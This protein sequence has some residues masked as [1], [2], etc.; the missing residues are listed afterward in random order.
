VLPLFF[1]ISLSHAEAIKRVQM[2]DL[3]REVRY[4]VAVYYD[5]NGLAADAKSARLDVRRIAVRHSTGIFHPKNIFA[6]L[7]TIEPDKNGYHAQTLIVASMSA[8]L[9]RAGWWENVEV[10]HIEQVEDGELTRLKDDIFGLLEGLERRVFE[11]AA[12]GHAALKAIKAFLRSTAQRQLRSSGGLL[13]TH[14]FDGGTAV[15]E[16]LEGVAGRDLRGLNLEIISPY[17]DAGPTS[18][19]L[20][21]LIER[22]APSEVRVFL[23]K[24]EAGE[25][26]CSKEIFDWVKLQPS[27][28]WS[29]LPKEVTRGG[30][31]ENAKGRTVHAKVYRFFSAQP[32]REFLFVGSANLTDPAHRR[33]GNLETGFLVQIDSPRRPDWWMELDGSKPAK[34]V[35]RNEEEGAVSNSGSRLTLRYWW[36]LKLA[37]AYWDDPG[38]SRVLSVSWTGIALFDIDPLERRQWTD[39]SPLAAAALELA[40]RSTS[41]LMVEGDRGEAVPVLVQEEGMKSK[42]S[43]LFDLSPSDILRYWSLLTAEQRAAFLEARAPEAAIGADANLVSRYEPVAEKF[44]FFDRFAGIF[45]SFGNLERHI[46]DS[47]NA[48]NNRPA[49]YRL[50][51][52]KY[53]SLGRLLDRVREDSEKSRDEM[54]EHYVIALCARQTVRELR[55]DFVDFFVEHE[56][57]A[58]RLDQQLAIAGILRDRLAEGDDPTMA[59]FLNWFEKWFLRR[60]TPVDLEAKT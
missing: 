53:D 60:A 10:C 50:F 23:P 19:P 57:D 3:L 14:F 11:K 52:Q 1:D 34:Y 15:G 13:E 17:F 55:R 5:Q 43:A 41:I 24:N 58:R 40:L 16:F 37:R 33:G 9:T 38:R 28:S 45:I 47:L 51:G 12:D 21:D 39:L 30:K 36:D 27:V 29:R 8:N 54:V 7:E 2:E 18:T 35:S 49:E 6:L 48:G 20:S 32:K 26:L 56:A 25:A 59:D 46:R 31:A 44:T 22:F 4:G 42:P